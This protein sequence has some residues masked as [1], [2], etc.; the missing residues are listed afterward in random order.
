MDKTFIF[1][2]VKTEDSPWEFPPGIYAFPDRA[3]Y[4]TKIQRCM[5]YSHRVWIQ[6]PRGKVRMRGQKSKSFKYVTTNE[7]MMKEFM[8]VKLK[9]QPLKYYI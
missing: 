3:T 7:E 5:S 1:C 2:E 6:G 9:A 4:F 8:W